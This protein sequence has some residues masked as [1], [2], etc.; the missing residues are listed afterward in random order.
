MEENMRY[1]FMKENMGEYLNDL[2]TLHI[3]IF[4]SKPWGENLMD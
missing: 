1:T 4:E 2:K 3:K